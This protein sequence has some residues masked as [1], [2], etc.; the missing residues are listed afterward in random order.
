MK[1]KVNMK[2]LV[3]NIKSTKNSPD[4]KPLRIDIDYTKPIMRRERDMR[5]EAIDLGAH[6]AQEFFGESK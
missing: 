1:P 5:R 6:G 2:K 4:P 3:A